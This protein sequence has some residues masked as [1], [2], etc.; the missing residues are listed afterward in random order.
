VEVVRAV[1]NAPRNGRSRA[2]LG[3]SLAGLFCCSAAWAQVSACDL[4]QDGV[5]NSADVNLA[6]NM[7]LGVTAC[8]ANVEGH[9]TCTVITVQRVVNASLGQACVTYSAGHSVALNWAASA[10]PN[11][12]GYNI[13]RGSAASGPYSKM[14]SSPTSGTSYT[15]STVQA[16]QTYYYVATSVDISGNES[17][18]SNSATA[19]IPSP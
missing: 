13:Y 15:D 18:Y 7:A 4:N 5:V 6:V 3:A 11:L 12:A 19:V 8:S 10:S 9:L 14:T 1:A 2:F 16:G 17:A